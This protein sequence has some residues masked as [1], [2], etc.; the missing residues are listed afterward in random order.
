MASG[1]S[2]LS[3]RAPYK[4]PKS[5]VTAKPS[6]RKGFKNFSF[7]T[8]WTLRFLT[9]SG[10]LDHE[11]GILAHRGL[12]EM[13]RAKSTIKWFSFR[14]FTIN[15]ALFAMA[16]CWLS[17]Y[18]PH[19]ITP[20]SPLLIWTQP[21]NDP[22]ETNAL[23]STLSSRSGGGGGGC[24]GKQWMPRC[25]AARSP[26]GHSCLAMLLL[27]NA[28]MPKPDPMSSF[29]KSATLLACLVTRSAA[30]PSA[31]EEAQPMEMHSSRGLTLPACA[32]TSTRA[33]PALYQDSKGVTGRRTQ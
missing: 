18:S 2:K 21:A 25:T 12:Y 13:L 5:A 32:T 3:S 30:E 19:G 26:R 14:K 20:V 23:L 22:R 9:F 33:A 10:E 27:W 15:L 11:V 16:V 24:C 17:R 29:A 6:E 7:K 1:A 31:E 4:P 8:H 28:R